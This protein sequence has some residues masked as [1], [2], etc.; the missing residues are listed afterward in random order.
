MDWLIA[1]R[2]AYGAASQPPGTRATNRRNLAMHQISGFNGTE[3]LFDFTSCSPPTAGAAHRC[4]VKPN[5]PLGPDQ[6]NVLLFG[7][8]AVGWL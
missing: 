8:A 6:V 7:E 5:T 3:G 1:L 4:P 2:A